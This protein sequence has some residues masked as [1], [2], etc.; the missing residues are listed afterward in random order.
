MPEII[1]TC[2]IIGKRDHLIGADRPTTLEKYLIKTKRLHPNPA[3]QFADIDH[4]MRGPEREIAI[5]FIS[6]FMASND[7]RVN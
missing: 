7:I 4:Y 6:G 2:F 5:G 3:Y 1:P